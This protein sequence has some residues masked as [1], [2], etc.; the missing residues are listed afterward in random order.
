MLSDR[1]Q[2]AWDDITRRYATEAAASPRSRRKTGGRN[3]RTGW[4]RQVPLPLLGLLLISIVLIFQEAVLGGLALAAATGPAWL[5]WRFWPQLHEDAIAASEIRR[6]R[7]EDRTRNDGAARSG[8]L[9]RPERRRSRAGP[10]PG[11][12]ATR[13]PR[14]PNA[15]RR[16]KNGRNGDHRSGQA[17]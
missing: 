10:V 13:H 15:G 11:V 17:R 5:L 14:G 2:G 3:Q 1:E 9:A 12:D 6:A 7:A 8:R 16:E 4:H